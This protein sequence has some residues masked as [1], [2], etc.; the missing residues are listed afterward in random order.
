MTES[1]IRI[2]SCAAIIL[3][4]SYLLY[5]ALAADGTGRLYW[6]QA[7][8]VLGKPYVP[9][10]VEWVQHRTGDAYP[11]PP[12]EAVPP[13]AAL[14]PYTGFSSEYPP[15]AILLFTLIRMV[16][17]QA[18][19]FGF[20]FAF[21][22]ASCSIAST[23]CVFLCGSGQQNTTWSMF[24]CSLGLL[25]W[26]LLTGPSAIIR[27][28]A[29]AALTLAA[30]MLSY[31]RSRPF[32]A[33]FMLGIGGSVKVWPLLLAPFLIASLNHGPAP[34]K[35]SLRLRMFIGLSANALLGFL[36]P[37]AALLL[38]GTSYTDVFSYLKFMSARP[39][40]VESV[41]GNLTAML[42]LMFNTPATIKF[43]F[44]SFNIISENGQMFAA[45]VTL[46]YA[47]TYVVGF[48]YCLKSE[49]R[50]LPALFGF[51]ITLTILCSK[52]FNGE[53]LIWLYPVFVFC[54]LRNLWLPSI[55]YAAGLICV[56]LVYWNV[57]SALNLE[58]AGTMWIFLKNVA[59]TGLAVLLWQAS[60]ADAT[61]KNVTVHA[62]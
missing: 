32:L 8:R 49:R 30:S 46:V 39:L 18:T 36:L 10:Y 15:G 51:V 34:Q 16:A 31:N 14:A 21:V 27:F 4:V 53:Y 62:S 35:I 29:A 20:T 13:A 28:D 43:D 59:L 37:H 24:K 25:I 2:A 54:L 19:S 47:I 48:C 60:R 41:P 55:A 11:G 57:Y 7:G 61:E 6:E 45:G 3:A 12:S 42:H 9:G 1:R 40:Q 22:M 52:V 50:Y 38:L 44:G 33:M 56:K 23:V 5:M 17:E 26:L 58:V